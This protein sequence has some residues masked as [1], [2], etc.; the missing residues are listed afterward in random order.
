MEKHCHAGL[1]TRRLHGHCAQRTRIHCGILLRVGRRYTKPFAALLAALA[2]V[3]PSMLSMA[4][5]A[6][7]TDPHGD[8]V[9]DHH[10]EH[11]EI[12]PIAIHGHH[13]DA[14]TPR[15]HHWLAFTGLGVAPTKASL[16]LPVMNVAGVV[17]GPVRP[18]DLVTSPVSAATHSPPLCGRLPLVLRI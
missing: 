15:H 9:D 2:F 4:T 14:E 16:G 10:G 1:K 6:H 11:V 12:I 8:V 7:L 13:H 17:N 5:F 3:A 18:P